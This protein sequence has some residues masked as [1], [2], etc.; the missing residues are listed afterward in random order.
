LREDPVVV[1]I[2]ITPVV[3]FGSFQPYEVVEFS[4]Y[5]QDL[6]MDTEKFLN[7]SQHLSSH[8]FYR[9]FLRTGA[10]PSAQPKP[11][12]L[13]MSMEAGPAEVAQ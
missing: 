3:V 2:R 9:N 7:L 1:R 10:V 5:R 11:V 8:D 12:G 6:L 4:E 13:L